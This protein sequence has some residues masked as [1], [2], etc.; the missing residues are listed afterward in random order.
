LQYINPGSGGTNQTRDLSSMFEI[1]AEQI[2]VVD[3]LSIAN[4]S[5]LLVQ[6][7]LAIIIQHA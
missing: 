2:A 3:P 7:L 6:M 4:A 5:I 1:S